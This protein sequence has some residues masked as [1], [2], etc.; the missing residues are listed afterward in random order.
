[1]YSCEQYQKVWPQFIIR[2]D[3]LTGIQGAKIYLFFLF[4]R[5]CSYFASCNETF[6]KEAVER[7]LLIPGTTS[8]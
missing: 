5:V 2:Y 1:M 4:T 3:D 8:L 6:Y 7:I